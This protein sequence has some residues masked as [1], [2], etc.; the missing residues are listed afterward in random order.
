MRSRQ[1]VVMNDH[2]HA[3]ATQTH[4]KLD[5]VRTCGDGGRKRRRRVLERN[6]RRAAMPDG[7]LLA[8][9]EC[10]CN[11]RLLYGSRAGD[12]TLE[13][14]VE[15]AVISFDA[16]ADGNASRVVGEPNG[17][18]TLFF[19]DQSLWSKQLRIHAHCVDAAEHRIHAL[20]LHD[21]DRNRID[22]S[23]VANIDVEVL[24]DREWLRANEIDRREDVLQLSAGKLCGRLARFT[25]RIV[26]I[27]Q[28]PGHRAFRAIKRRLG[29]AYSFSLFVRDRGLLNGKGEWLDDGFDNFT[30][31]QIKQACE[32]SLARDFCVEHQR[33][34]IRVRFLA[35]NHRFGDRCTR[36]A[37][38]Q[39]GDVEFSQRQ[40]A[41]PGFEEKL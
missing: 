31:L 38:L 23:A 20:L 1:S 12:Y 17:K 29:S 5:P 4:V 3:I 9:D 26:W 13:F 28:G 7:A 19:I 33:V 21:L 30:K 6:K 32:E 41:H 15:G 16:A 40:R 18:L 27:P 35:R 37:K 34:S 2:R 25:L 8:H 11:C 10:S 14:D 24:A 36:S 39:V 22:V